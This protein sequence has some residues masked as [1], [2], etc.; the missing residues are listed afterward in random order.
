MILD[1]LMK[2]ENEGM[3]KF[4]FLISKTE[5]IPYINKKGMIDKKE[6]KLYNFGTYYNKLVFDN[7]QTSINFCEYNDEIL[8]FSVNDKKNNNHFGAFNRNGE[9]VIYPIFDSVRFLYENTNYLVCEFNKKYGLFNKDG[10]QIVPV[11]YSGIT[12]SNEDLLGVYYKE[13]WGVIDI[14][15]GIENPKDFS[16]YVIPPIYDYITP[17][18]NGIAMVS[19]NNQ[20]FRINKSNEKVDVKIK[21]K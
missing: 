9:L 21:V 2:Y 14:N 5:N 1:L 17:F 19:Y 7:W 4:G 20:T 6:V 18:E 10:K 15:A 3:N 11:K 13:K 8:I 12:N 16:Q